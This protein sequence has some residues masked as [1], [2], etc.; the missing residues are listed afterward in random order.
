MLTCQRL[1]RGN[2]EF[3]GAAIGVKG[4]GFGIKEFI[5]ICHVSNTLS[6]RSKTAMWVKISI[7]Y[8]PTQE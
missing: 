5:F 4:K 6:R 3:P 1:G 7:W 8:K 2:L